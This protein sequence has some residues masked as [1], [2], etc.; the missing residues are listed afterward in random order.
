MALDAKCAKYLAKA[1]DART[2][3]R[4]LIIQHCDVPV[5]TFVKLG[6]PIRPFA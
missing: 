5:D 2:L 4:N 1:L 6:L 3:L